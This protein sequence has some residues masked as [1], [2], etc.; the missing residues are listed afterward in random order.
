MESIFSCPPSLKAILRVIWRCCIFCCCCCCGCDDD[1]KSVVTTDC[2]WN[3]R[4]KFDVKLPM[5]SCRFCL[6]V[7][8]KDVVSGNDLIGEAIDT[9]DNI[10]FDSMMEFFA[11]A[12]GKFRRH[13]AR[14]ATLDDI[15][16]RR[17]LTADERA[18]LSS[19]RHYFLRRPKITTQS[20]IA[21]RKQTRGGKPGEVHPENR[22]DGK[23]RLHK[24]EGGEK[25]D[26]GDLYVHYW[27]VHKDLAN[28]SSDENLWAKRILTSKIA[29]FARSGETPG[30]TTTSLSRRD[31]YHSRVSLV[32][33]QFG[34]GLIYCHVR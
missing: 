30:R 1:D 4:F 27:L 12:A 16:R 29:G 31:N 24:M 5:H 3:W 15:A 34:C 6:Q 22:K 13:K 33:V 11:D 25:K 8:D 7:W 10:G 28:S 32:K 14:R 26:C 9:E 19:D 21:G 18:E 23:I 17:S 2:E 20:L